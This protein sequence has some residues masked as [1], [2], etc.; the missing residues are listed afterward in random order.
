MGAVGMLACAE[1]RRRWR[2][3][4][5]LTLLVGIVGAIVLASVAGARRSDSS[6]ARFN[7]YSRS[8]DAEISVGNTTAAQLRALRRVREVEAV[9]TLQGFFLEAPK[10]TSQN[11]ALASAND[12]KLGTVVDRARVV[13]GRKANP[14]AADE[15]TI[16]EGLAAQLH[17]T[18]GDHF[19]VRGYTVAQGE[20][21]IAG[22][23]N[24]GPPMGPRVNLR[25]VGIVRRPLD[26]GDRG[27]Q[28]GV[29]VLTPA[30]TKKYVHEIYGFGTILRIRT[31]HGAADVPTVVA[32]ARR[33]FPPSVF[34]FS[35]QSLGIE[36]EGARS[37]IDVLTI[38]LW[39]LAGVAL[40]AGLVAVGIVLTR[41]VS[42]LVVDQPTL[43]ALGL[44]RGQRIAVSGPQA[45]VV[46]GAGALLAGLGALAASP[47]FPIGVARRADPDPGL[48]ADWLVLTLGLLA[49]MALVATIAAV[50][51]L[52]TVVRA[53]P[54]VA[55]R[56]RRRVSA[57]VDLAAGA[58][59]P[60]TAISGLR[61]AL[62]P[63]RGDAAV[64][65][66]SAFLG[67]IV[68]VLGV[69][70]V[71][72]FVSSL[73]HLV[74]TPRLSGWTWD[75]ATHDTA[76]S[77]CDRADYG[78]RHVRGVTTIAATCES[79]IPIDGHPVSGWGIRPLRGTF[80]PEIVEGRE[81]RT[82]HEVALGSVTLNALGKSIGDTVHVSVAHGKVAYRVVG[83]TVFPTLSAAQPLADGAL[84]TNAGFQPIYDRSN[85]NRDL[86]GRFA[87]GADRAAVEHRIAHL[88]GPL[89]S[90]VV[91]KTPVEVDRLR[92]I[93]W[94]PAT[95]AVLLIVLALLAVGHA[96]VTSVRRRRRELALLKA[97]GFDRRQV[98]ATVAWQATTLATI[99]LVA[100]I[101]AGLI[102]GRLVWQLVAN[103]LG[104]STASTTPTLA[105]LLVIPGVLALVNLIA[106]FPARAA[107][108]TR[109]AVALRSE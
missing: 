44:T 42:L 14:H 18:V 17:L 73:D 91:Y 59:L 10:G 30:F 2:G 33:I 89:T 45:M 69:I 11:L 36:T 66:R 8:S 71:F 47:L 77:L 38:A 92:Q 48:H 1:I 28:G 99:G 55:A 56:S 98:R 52:R 84:F 4:V 101:P 12:T 79:T 94:F 78:L 61:M 19:P 102:I 63:G 85:F 64:P 109:P 16:G 41:E 96:L 32:A 13:A 100:G 80:P 54:D 37:A 20:K 87:A 5:V 106:F 26:L 81:P 76:N 82:P 23:S 108:R 24:P 9:A 49:V 15:L 70:A 68:G 83:R 74:A 97:I 86:V 50:A 75:F 103:G 39:I 27:A 65:V 21:A 57:T 31:R 105:V 90:P 51:A 107:A 7:T 6:L 53:S 46:A 88:G 43:R 58:G 40:V 35:V 93:N 22:N 104:V 25:I 67:T 60:P 95:L 29:V 34:G 3:T 62:E 72:T